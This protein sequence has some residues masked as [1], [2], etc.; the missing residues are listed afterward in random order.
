MK[1]GLKSTRHSVE[2][3]VGYLITVTIGIELKLSIPETKLGT[4]TPS[5]LGLLF[6]ITPR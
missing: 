2:S 6:H 1:L 3:T 5:S 4:A